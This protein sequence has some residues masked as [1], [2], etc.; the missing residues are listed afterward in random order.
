MD[1]KQYEYA[2]HTWKYNH[3]KRTRAF[4]AK[5]TGL[6]IS[7]AFF[8]IFLQWLSLESWF[9]F[10]IIFVWPLALFIYSD[11]HKPYSYALKYRMKLLYRESSLN[12]FYIS[13]IFSETYNNLVTG[14]NSLSKSLTWT[15]RPYKESKFDPRIDSGGK[16]ASSYIR[17]HE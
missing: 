8:S 4:I 14:H 12:I 6:Q 2:T 16:T 3:N 5:R 15:L 1:L 10:D 7:T 11:W 9:N 17:D 13:W